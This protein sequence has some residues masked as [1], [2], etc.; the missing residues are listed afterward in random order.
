MAFNIGDFNKTLTTVRQ[1]LLQSRNEQGHWQGELSSS[2]LSTATAVLALS[3]ADRDQH[4]HRIRRGL[5][6]LAERANPDGGWGDTIISPSNISTTILA[7]A[8]FAIAEDESNYTNA[9]RQAEQW[10]DKKAG[11]SDA[12]TLSHAITACYGEDRTFSV[13]ILTHCALSGRLGPGENV[14][15]SIEPLPFEFALA[16]FWC[17]KWL[18]ISVVS[19]A[20]PALI[21]IGQVRHHHAPPKNIVTRTI[22]NLARTGTLT[23]LERIQPSSGGFLEATPLTSFVTMS[24][25]AS[26]QGESPVVQKAVDFLVKSQRDD[27]SWPIDT[28]LATWG[29]TL[30]INALA[31]DPSFHELLPRTERETI[32][33]WLLAQQNRGIHP[34]TR[35]GV[36]GWAWT[37]LPGGVPDADDTA[38]ALLALHHLGIDTR[39]VRDAA[40]LGIRWFLQLQNSGGG[41]PT[42]CRGWGKLPFDR[43]A[44]DL[45]AHFL[46]TMMA[47]TINGRLPSRMKQKA[48]KAIRKCF[49]YLDNSQRSDGSWIPLWFGNANAP[50]EE[51]P[52]YGSAIVVSALAGLPADQ[53][54]EY[55]DMLMK[56]ANYLLTTQNPDCGWGGAKGVASSIEETALS[57]SALAR[58]LAWNRNPGASL[59]GIDHESLRKAIRTGTAWLIEN[60]EHG[61]RMNSAPIG[62]YFARLWYYEK[63]YPLIFTTQA[64]ERVNSVIDLVLPEP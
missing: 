39:R 15:P 10:I 27:G 53:S 29:T 47:W 25:V 4:R 36:G 44:P 21:A 7:W 16:P 38:G 61:T 46:A 54:A 6:W 33:N 64:L 22:R 43:S 45:S 11:G 5:D 32:V 18:R 56:G 8:S 24:L 13:P 19:Y 30:S 51:N 28:N 62:L 48:E 9:V 12:I 40:G 35:A 20:L 63:L 49:V 26:N 1:T 17:L 37:D 3:L 34:Y 2:A 59:S 42:F 55:R 31:A 23:L 57:V 52:V 14:W 58:T 41:I 50:G 60:T